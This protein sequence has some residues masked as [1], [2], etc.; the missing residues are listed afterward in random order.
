MYWNEI[1]SALKMADHVS[2]AA[3][4]HD[5]PVLLESGSARPDLSLHYFRFLISDFRARSWTSGCRTLTR[6]RSWRAASRG[7]WAR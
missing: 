3:P 1:A 4:A 6:R 7:R 2:S 5:V